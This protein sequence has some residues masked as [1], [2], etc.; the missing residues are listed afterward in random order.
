M[1][2]LITEIVLYSIVGMIF[3]VIG[4]GIIDWAIPCD[5]DDE[6]KKGNKAVAWVSASIYIGTGIIIKTGVQTLENSKEYSRFLFGVIDTSF[7][8][9]IGIVLFLAGYFV[10]DKLNRKYRF[11]EELQKGNEA[12]GI[13]ILGIFVALALIVSG[14]I[15]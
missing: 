5:F 6:I 8:T 15:Q 9:I 13:V 4:H 12:A 7:Y 1:I 10:M 11:H 14:V 3:M 2:T